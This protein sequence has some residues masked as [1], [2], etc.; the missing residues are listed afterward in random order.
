MLQRT[1][2][3]PEALDAATSRL[4]GTNR[5]DILREASLLLENDESYKAMSFAHNPFGDG[6]ASARIVTTS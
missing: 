3:P 1:T 2:V 6:Q 5:V 4:V